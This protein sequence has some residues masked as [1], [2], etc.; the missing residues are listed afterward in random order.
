MPGF[1]FAR[2]LACNFGRADYF[3]LLR[4]MSSTEL[5]HWYEHFSE[6]PMYQQATQWQLAHVAAGVYGPKARPAHFMPHFP[7]PKTEREQIAIWQSMT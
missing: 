2:Q 4:G 3:A 6:R 7:K 1:A 5:D